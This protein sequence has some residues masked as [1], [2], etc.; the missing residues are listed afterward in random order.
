MLSTLLGSE[1]RA[2]VLCLLLTRPRRSHHV[3]E[4]IRLT[5][6][7]ASGVQREVARLEQ[8]GLVVSQRT[9]EG[10][11][12]LCVVEE[13]ELL[14]P[15]QALVDLDADA[16]RVAQTVPSGTV[17]A[18]DES[19]IESAVH[20]AVRSCV[21][22][23]LS[24]LKKARVERAVLFGSAADPASPTAPRDLDVL[25]RLG[26]PEK[27]RAARY[28][29]LRSALEEA[30]GLPV[31]LVEDEAIGNPYLRAEIEH[32]GVTLVAAA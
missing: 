8:L 29:S 18:G 4:L 24:A 21:P 30:G 20:E 22:S 2:R 31:D 25:V 16:K 7:S 10:R 19:A 13:H 27:G 1:T 11:K 6:G 17:A 23:L 28:F 14:E 3:R 12:T 5:G 9:A 32:T 26:G 15:L